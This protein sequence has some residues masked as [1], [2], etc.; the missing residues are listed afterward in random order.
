MAPKMVGAGVVPPVAVDPN[1][2]GAGVP[3]TA[4]DP[5]IVGE[6]VRP[7][8]TREGAAVGTLVCKM[9]CC[10]WSLTTATTLLLSP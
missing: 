1:T 8:D 5:N 3:P 2:L 10:C 7:F 4:M 6:I 9:R